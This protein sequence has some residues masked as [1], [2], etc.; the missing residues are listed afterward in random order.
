MSLTHNTDH[1]E[2]MLDLLIEQFKRKPNFEALLASF[3]A[4]IQEIEDMFYDLLTK[5][6]LDTAF[7][8]QLDVIGAIVGEPRN[9]R[10]DEKYRIWIKAR[11][12]LNV[13]SGT[14]DE[15]LEILQL[16]LE[17]DQ[18]LIYSE[19]YPAELEVNVIGASDLSLAEQVGGV[20]Q[21]AKPAG[22]TAWLIVSGED[23]ENTFLF[24]DDSEITST[25]QGFADDEETDPGGVLAE[26]F[27]A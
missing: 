4:S 5:R 26:V 17:P 1:A 20:L 7:G 21:K 18:T 8:K 2:Q 13:S 9:A 10:E 23:E 14:P 15:I 12:K 16:V 6:G 3:A 11:I 24:S 19:R 22:V 27:G 25:T